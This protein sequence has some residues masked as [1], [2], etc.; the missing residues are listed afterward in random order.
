[1]PSFGNINR[2]TAAAAR[3]FAHK[4]AAR[5]VGRMNQGRFRFEQGEDLLLVGG[6]DPR[7]DGLEGLRLIGPR[8]RGRNIMPADADIGASLCSVAPGDGFHFDQH[9]ARKVFYREAGACRRFT[10]EVLGVD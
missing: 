9:A 3:L 2:G 7:R 1:M 5:C 6:I 8:C 4:R 10:G